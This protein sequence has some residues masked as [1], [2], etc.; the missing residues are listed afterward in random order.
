MVNSKTGVVTPVSVGTANIIAE[1]TGGVVS[2]DAIAEYTI[3]VSKKPQTISAAYLSSIKKYL[4]AGTVNLKAKTSGDGKLTFASSNVSVATVSS[5]GVIKLIAAGTSTITIKA[6]ATDNYLSASKTLKL[7]VLPMVSQ[8]L[9]VKYKT[10]TKDG[11]TTYKTYKSPL[12][13]DYTDGSLQ[14]K[15]TTTGTGAITYASSDKTIA[16][17]SSKGK[18]TFTGYGKVKITVTAK[19]TSKYKKAT[20]VVT[21][22][23][24]PKVVKFKSKITRDSEGN[25]YVYWKRDSKVT[26]YQV[27]VFAGNNAKKATTYFYGKN[28]TK[29]NLGVLK[30]KTL[31]HVR[32]R[33]YKTSSGKKIYG[34]WDYGSFYNK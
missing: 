22:T 2:A 33:G 4:G 30:N 14:L 15:S 20:K 26:G 28:T 24:R 25:V 29:A 32:I 27:K 6:S 10:V 8:K 19:K 21:L 9:T 34:D 17:V 13:Y 1:A 5:A 7:T 23:I 3:K 11:K 31:Y 18:V 16:K 12:T